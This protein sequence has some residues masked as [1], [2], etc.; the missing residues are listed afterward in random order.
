MNEPF[1]YLIVAPL[2]FAASLV[3]TPILARVAR[4]TGYLDHPDPRKSHSEP[5]TG[6]RWRRKPAKS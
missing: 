3:L 2:A 4:L 6:A 1:R 5:K